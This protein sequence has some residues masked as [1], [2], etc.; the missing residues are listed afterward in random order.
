VEVVLR[1]LSS[2]KT[3]DGPLDTT[4]SRE[5]SPRDAR[6][7]SAIHAPAAG[8]HNIEAQRFPDRFGLNFFSEI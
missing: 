1:G 5:T 7:A 8:Q 3:I 2:I 4:R 6:T